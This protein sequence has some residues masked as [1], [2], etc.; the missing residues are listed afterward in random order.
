MASY[1][2]VANGAMKLSN[3]AY[4]KDVSRNLAEM[5]LERALRSFNANTFSSWTLSGTTATRTLDS[6]NTSS[7]ASSNFGSSGLTASVKL[8]VDNYD[9]SQLNAVWSSSTN[10]QTNDLV[11]SGGS[12]YR[13]LIPN[14]NKTPSSNNTYWVVEQS[15]VNWMWLSSHAYSSEDIVYYKSSWYRCISA[16]TSSASILPTNTSYW[17]NIPNLYGAY[18]GS[19]YYYVNDTI[20]YSPLST[21][22]YCTIAGTG[23]GSW[24]YAPISWRWRSSNPYAVGDIVYYAGVWYTC[25]TAHTS[26]S[27]FDSS[28]WTNNQTSSFLSST[29]A[30][31]NW[32]S[33]SI[34][35]NPSDVVYYSVTSQ[36][37]RCIASHTS[38][39]SITPS[40]TTY[41]INAPLYSTAWDSG[42]QYSQY[43]RVRYN[44][45][46]Y[47]SLQNSNYGQNP[48][49]ATTYWIGADTTNSS[50]TWNSSTSYSAGDYRCYGRVWYKCLS[51]G[52]NKTPNNSSNW[53]STWS[54]SWN[55]TTGAPVIYAEGR[56]TL[57]DGSAT[58]ATQ[59][60]AIVQPA[61]LFPNAIG[62]TG[63]IS[64][65]SGGTVDSY[66]SNLG[67]YASQT[68]S[69]TNYSAVI[70]STYGS[71][72]AITLSSTTVKG[73]LAAPS[74]ST[75]PFAPLYSTGGSVKG[76]SS[77]ASPSID[78]AQISRSPYVPQ[79]DTVPGGSDGLATNWTAAY[80]GNSLSLSSTTVIGIPGARTPVR[81]Y[82]NGNLTIGG[83]SIQYLNINGPVILY[84]NGDLFITDSSSIG[85]I[86]VGSTGSA[87]IHVAGAFKADA[88]G[89]GILS[90]NTDPKSL[91]II[92]DSTSTTSSFYSEGVNPLYGVIYAPYSTSTNGY[93]NNNNSTNIYGAVSAS[94]IT[95][96]GANMNIHY[97]TSLRYAMLPGVD[98]PFTITDWRELTDPNEQANMP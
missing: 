22:I 8:R 73:Y 13:C 67:T 54:N 70:A 71:D 81:Y 40:N 50:Y 96:S 57:P 34:K 46:W 21:W 60:R 56:V 24:N 33:S 6:S 49:T 62:A 4:A 78:K 35:Y 66:D 7:L 86:N 12:W 51:A 38:S 36:W 16:H 10:Y 2:A 95:Y 89:E 17:T 77:P 37:Y 76:Y 68:G 84:V 91:I 1:L 79:F 92:S 97:D 30:L 31:F 75:T 63:A 80:K 93:Y 72:T 88:G 47:L 83:S 32:N 5:G 44:G 45:V 64:A 41:W 28:K 25:S 43:D 55:V 85:R 94:K 48:S 26:G 39:G 27:S 98:Q 42:C 90:Y 14:S 23:G 65:N 11:A 53:T 18:N 69:S 87:E 20:Y 9:A 15:P 82:Y 74:N 19:T 58:V 29:N 3:R 59:L 52:T 61:S